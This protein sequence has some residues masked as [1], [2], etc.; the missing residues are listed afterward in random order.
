M[1]VGDLV[2]IVV[3]EER[4]CMLGATRVIILAER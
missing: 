3:G 1:Q 2:R 4:W